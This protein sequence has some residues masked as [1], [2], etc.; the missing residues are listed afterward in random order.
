MAPTVHFKV[1]EFFSLLGKS[2]KWNWIFTQGT[3][4]S[5]KVYCV[6]TF[7]QGRILMESLPKQC[8]TWTHCFLWSEVTIVCPQ[9]FVPVAGSWTF[10]PLLLL[11]CTTRRP[12]CMYA[13][14]R[15]VS[16]QYPSA[17]S[18]LSS[19]LDTLQ[20]MISIRKKMLKNFFGILCFFIFFSI[21][22]NRAER[23]LSACRNWEIL[24]Y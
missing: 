5:T 17:C 21:F 11:L 3:E 13:R 16:Y 14:L 22:A 2:F 12:A 6:F 4:T 20:H 15:Q 9:V 18:Q 10:V 24:L 7:L 19:W 1:W 23:S 8:L